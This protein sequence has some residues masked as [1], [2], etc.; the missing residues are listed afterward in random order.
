MA[1]ALLILPLGAHT[2]AATVAPQLFSDLKWRMIG[3]FR[4][5]RAVAVGG[6]PGAGNTFYFGAVDGGVWKTTDAGTVWNPVFDNQPVASIGA[7]EVS[8]A[9]PNVIYVG[10]GESDIRSDLASG[11]GVYKS[12]DGGETWAYAGLA[13]TRQISKIALDPTTPDI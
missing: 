8:I 5:G 11:A 10:T 6:V 3:P 9:N 1:A 2:L 13:D 12:V 7:L 4:G